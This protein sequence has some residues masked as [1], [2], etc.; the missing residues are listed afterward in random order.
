MKK[1]KGKRKKEKL[2][3]TRRRCH[4]HVNATMKPMSAASRMELLPT[5][6]DETPPVPLSRAV[7]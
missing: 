2:Q 4:D 6:A 5:W 7:R 1:E 3:G